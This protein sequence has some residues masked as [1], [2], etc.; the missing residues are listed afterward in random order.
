METPSL[1]FEKEVETATHILEW[2][3][4]ATGSTESRAA[5]KAIGQMS[6]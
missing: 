2:R 4:Q 3:D 1:I 6:D 5:S